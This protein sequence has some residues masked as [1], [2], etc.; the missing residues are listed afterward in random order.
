MPVLH[1][2]VGVPVISPNSGDKIIVGQ[3]SFHDGP[4][5][6]ACSAEDL[7]M[8]SDLKAYDQKVTVESSG[9]LES[10]D[11]RPTRAA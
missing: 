6:V 10:E 5:N 3:G 11:V 4:A 8:S 1:A 7:I 2:G 9:A